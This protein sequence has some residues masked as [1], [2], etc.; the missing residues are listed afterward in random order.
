MKR[1]HSAEQIVGMREGTYDH[2][3]M[4]CQVANSTM[5]WNNTP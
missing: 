3:L 1:R 2:I 4:A 5:R